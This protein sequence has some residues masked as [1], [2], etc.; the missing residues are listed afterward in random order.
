[1]TMLDP[2]DLKAMAD[3][4][5][6]SWMKGVK[7]YELP[8]AFEFSS[9]ADWLRLLE[10]WN[11]HC[12]ET[13]LLRSTVAT[14]SAALLEQD[15]EIQTLESQLVDTDGDVEAVQQDMYDLQLELEEAYTRISQLEYELS[16]WEAE[17]YGRR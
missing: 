4:G 14:L 17:Y 7:R 9:E 11:H 8:E 16:A 13:A 15:H 3:S 5:N 6:Y 1:M 12:D 10:L 2:N